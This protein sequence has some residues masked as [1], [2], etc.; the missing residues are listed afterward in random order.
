MVSTQLHSGVFGHST[1]KTS[2]SRSRTVVKPILKK[3]HSQ[4]SSLDLDRGWDDQPSPCFP[5]GTGLGTYEG[6]GIVWAGRDW[7]FGDGLGMAGDTAAATAGAGGMAGAMSTTAAAR[8][9]Y[10]HTRSISAA[11][12]ASSIA[13]S[14]SGRNGGTFVHPFQQTPQTSTPPLSYTNSRPSFDNN[15]ITTTGYSPTITEHD[16]DDDHQRH[17]DDVDPY[18]SLN[19]TSSALRPSYFQQPGHRRPSL[20]SQRT[21]SLSDVSQPLRIPTT[22]SDSA[23]TRLFASASVNHSKS[24]LDSSLPSTFLADSPL[25]STVPRASTASGLSRL[26]TNV[27]SSPTAPVSPLRSSFEMSGFR[28]RSRSEVDTA[29]HQEHV[30]EARRKFDAKERV[31]NEKYDRELLRKQERAESRVAHRMEKTQGRLR[32]G[33]AGNGSLS[34]SA[35]SS[36]TD[37]RTL[38][39]RMHLAGFDEAHEKTDFAANGY[40]TIYPEHTAPQRVDN[41]QFTSSPKR[42]KTAKHRTVG[43]WTAF[44]LWLR[45]RLLKLGRH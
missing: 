43:L 39:S 18:P 8:A 23:Q 1:G 26:Q 3:L 28:I 19:S 40:D 45:T 34:G 5:A 44:M 25:S 11:S 21:N 35:M 29:T 4:D 22:R 10:S 16:D 30:R 24:E 32:K 31:K 20:A 33:S 36:G 38:S 9:K 13:T 6:D 41:V 42:N 27:A 12:Y 37:L 17:E 15:A 7:A 14:A 2:K